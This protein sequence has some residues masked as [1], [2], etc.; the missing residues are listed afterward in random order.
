MS[1]EAALRRQVAWGCRILALWEHGDMTLGHLSAR[2]P[3]GRVLIKRREV[4]LGEVTPADLVAIDLDG[5]KV[6]GEGEVHLE[7]ALHTEVYRA[8]PDVGAVVHSHPPY[9]TALGA[10]GGR[11]Q[12]LTHDA[13]L[14]H[15]GLGWFEE[16]AELVM[17]PEMGRAVARALGER[18][19]VILR[20]HGVLVV[21]KDVPWAVF[22]AV[23]LERALQLQVIAAS[24]GPLRPMSPEM[25][26]RLF[27]SKYRDDLVA[28]YW[29]YLIRE[30]R[31]RGLGEGMAEDEET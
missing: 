7:A 16:T 8:R 31:R 28:T 26:R 27:P 30:A 21:G 20:N 4:A 29:R 19:A 13:V 14:F 3:D 2:T 12:L 25:A 5:N 15:D 11:L 22:A 1:A 18:R 6:E 24:L 9:A 23:T 10:T 17:S